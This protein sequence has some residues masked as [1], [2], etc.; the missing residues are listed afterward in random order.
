MI[1]ALY[2]LALAGFVGLMAVAA[3]EDFRRF[4]IPNWLTLGLCALW[5]VS[6][7][8][9]PSLSSALAALGCAVIVFLV[10]AV[11]FAR[12]YIGGGD[13]K[14]L[15]AAVLWTGPAGLSSLLILTALLGGVLALILVSPLG[16]YLVAGARA[17]LGAPAP[18][19]A[20]ESTPVPYGIAI[21]AASL[22]LILPQQFN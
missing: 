9:A 4:T 2:Y 20:I 13:V 12:G 15:A 16:A 18:A 11:L 5:P 1:A 10:G 19:P 3:F 22:I 8:A 6:L 17:Q 7:V 21:A 14:L